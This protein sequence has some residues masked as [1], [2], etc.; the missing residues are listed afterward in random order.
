MSMISKLFCF[1]FLLNLSSGDDDDSCYG[2]VSVSGSCAT[3]NCFEN[4]HILGFDITC[5]SDVSQ[6]AC[7]SKCCSQPN[8]KGFDYSSDDRR[9]CT[10]S[11]SRAD[12]PNE[13]QQSQDHDYLSCEKNEV[14]GCNAEHEGYEGTVFYVGHS[15]TDFNGALNYC[16]NNG[17]TVA[18]IKSAAD[19][20]RAAAACSGYSCWVGLLEQG[21]MWGTW[22]WIDGE[23]LSYSNWQAG[24]PN[25]HEGNDEKHAIMNCCSEYAD[26]GSDGKWYDAPESHYGPRALCMGQGYQYEA[27]RKDDDKNESNDIV[28]IVIVCILLGVALITAVACVHK[29]KKYFHPGTVVADYRATPQPIRG[30][31][32][33]HSVA[34][35]YPSAVLVATAPPAGVQMSTTAQVVTSPSSNS[36]TRNKYCG[37]CGASLNAGNKFC[38][39][40]GAQIE[41]Y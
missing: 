14:T 25:N 10:S 3:F 20:S 9:C 41:V 24:E 39:N 26:H 12:H 32:S 22:E 40:C 19:Q 31:F 23:S 5:E 36:S 34:N 27:R 4:S 11:V 2:A 30:D 13:F 1:Y 18:I 15:S 29:T 16:K 17:D 28:G 8:C 37:N 6:E 7:V 33:P 21:G 38:V 35:S